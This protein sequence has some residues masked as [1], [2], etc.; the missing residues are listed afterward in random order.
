MINLEAYG[1]LFRQKFNRIFIQSVLTKELASKR[2][3]WPRSYNRVKLK[4]TI[5]YCEDNWVNSEQH[6]IQSI[7]MNKCSQRVFCKLLYS[8]KLGK[9]FIIRLISHN[10]ILPEMILMD[11]IGPIANNSFSRKDN[12]NQAITIRIYDNKCLTI[13]QQRNS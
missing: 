2:A 11:K 6:R 8:S 1:E 9:W 3:I 5:C 13:F 10:T 4:I 12:I 7:E